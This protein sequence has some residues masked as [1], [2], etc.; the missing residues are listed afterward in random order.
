[1]AAVLVGT[2]E[3]VGH[4]LDAVV[5]R[6]AVG[7]TVWRDQVNRIRL[8][9]TAGVGRVFVFLLEG[10]A[11][12]QRLALARERDV[13]RARLGALADVQV[14][15]QVV[16]AVHAHHPF[17]R[18]ARVIDCGGIRGH[19][20]AV[21]QQLEA[22]FLEPGPPERWFDALDG[23]QG[24]QGQGQKQDQYQRFL[25]HDVDSRQAGARMVILQTYSAIRPMA[26]AAAVL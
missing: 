17:E 21:D 26:L 3:L 2:V 10:V 18:D 25:V 1:M 15:E 22:G 24:L 12:C 13:E 23:G 14:Q 4:A 8:I 7:E 9:E 5:G 11:V 19:V 16:G 6:V 20:V